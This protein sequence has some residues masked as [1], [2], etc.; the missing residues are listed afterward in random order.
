MVRSHRNRGQIVVQLGRFCWVL[1]ARVVLLISGPFDSFRVLSLVLQLQRQV[2]ACGE[3][4]GKGR[5][6][7]AYCTDDGQELR[8][9]AEVPWDA[10][11]DTL[12]PALG[13]SSVAAV[14]SC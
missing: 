7:H 13:S 2:R 14:I 6:F 10:K 1:V 5:S 4:G 12:L 9:E 3:G 8:G 11:S